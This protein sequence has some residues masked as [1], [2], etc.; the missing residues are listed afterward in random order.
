MKKLVATASDQRNAVVTCSYVALAAHSY[1][2]L[3]YTLARALYHVSI[4]LNDLC[5]LAD[6][7]SD[8]SGTCKSYKS[9]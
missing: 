5:L 3:K 6:I 7:W 9:L 1:A 8:S 2:L 4:T